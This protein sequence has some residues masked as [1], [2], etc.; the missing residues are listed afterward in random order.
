MKDNEENIIPIGLIAGE[1]LEL[2]MQKITSNKKKFTKD[3]IEILTLCISE[4]IRAGYCSC[5]R[6]EGC[7]LVM[8]LIK[9]DLDAEK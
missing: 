6:Q 4:I 3:V 1:V 5:H 7:D 9:E 8:K 2:I